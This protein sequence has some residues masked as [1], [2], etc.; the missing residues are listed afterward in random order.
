M[1]KSI[2]KWILL[3]V[4]GACVC[5][6][7]IAA[8]VTG[9]QYFHMGRTENTS[10]VYFYSPGH[11]SHYAAGDF[12]P[13]HI[14][15]RD[16]QKVTRVEFWVNG[17][18]VE[19]KTSPLQGGSSPMPLVLDWQPPAGG[20]YTLVA[21]AVNSRGEKTTG[22]IKVLVS[23]EM[24]AAT[25]DGD[26]D[27]IID[28]AD[29]CPG[30]PGLEPDGCPPV[31]PDADGDGVEDALDECP[32][33]VGGI[34]AAGCPDRDGDGVPDD[35]DVCPDETGASDSPAGVGC[36]S[37][38]A[39][40]RDGDGV[41]DAED[42]C[43][44][45]PGAVENAGCPEDTIVPSGVDD[46]PGAFPAEDRDGDGIAD[47][48][49]LCPGEAGPADEH[50]CPVDAPDRDGDGIP[51][52]AD[53]CPDEP[54]D[55]ANMGCPAPEEA[56]EDSSGGFLELIP[57][58]A[59]D[60]SAA[61]FVEFQALSFSVAQPYDEVYCY[62]SVTQNPPDLYGPFHFNG[63]R[64]WDITEYMGSMQVAVHEGENLPVFV[65]CFAYS[66][67]SGSSEYHYI[68]QYAMQHPASDWDGHIITARVDP[69]DNPVGSAQ[70]DTEGFQATYRICDGACDPNL[71]ASPVLGIREDAIMGRVLFW[72]WDG[73]PANVD[74][75]NIY[76]NGT[77]W[78]NI[79]S[80]YQGINVDSLEPAC[81]QT[82]SF[83][84]TAAAGEV[85]SPMSNEVNWAGPPC[86]QRV[87]ITFDKIEIYNVRDGLRHGEVGP[88]F[89]RFYATGSLPYELSFDGDDFP[90][91]VVLNSEG[92]TSVNAL[93]R[94]IRRLQENEGVCSGYTCHNYS[95]PEVSYIEMDLTAGT[96]LTVGVRITDEDVGGYDTL[97]Q[98]EYTFPYDEIVPGHYSLG[99]GTVMVTYWI[100]TIETEDAGGEGGTG[101]QPDLQ[102]TRVEK[103]PNSGQVRSWVVNNGAPIT[104]QTLYILYM[105]RDGGTILLEQLYEGVSL[106]TDE[107]VWLQTSRTDIPISN[108]SVFVDSRFQVDEANEDNNQLLT[109][110]TYAVRLERIWN[111]SF[112]ENFL[113]QHVEFEYFYSVGY[114]PDEDHVHW[115]A[116]RLR[117]PASDYDR[118]DRD[119]PL[120]E[121]NVYPATAETR[122]NVFITPNAGDNIYVILTGDEHDP[123]QSDYLGMIFVVYPPDQYQAGRIEERYVTEGASRATCADM[124][125]LGPENEFYAWFV[126]EPLP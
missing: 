57:G 112:C 33:A 46:D 125:P 10:L 99:N 55:P 25:P 36:P 95:A 123:N 106:A 30:Q 78:R 62:A 118:I 86:S 80:T 93:F 89:G 96:D 56:G 29:A 22:E 115:V 14:V 77:Y 73:D 88:V 121:R 100:N 94:T 84:I 110:V 116:N 68:G 75:F 98:D 92:S 42:A 124:E 65:S 50:G 26:G 12:V 6:G 37:V 34:A 11:N 69:V 103:E 45:E 16:E 7:L 13:I 43:P 8:G 20:T 41:L 52:S 19:S 83:R 17:R 74:Q 21:Q 87:R 38:T 49:D 79:R 113:Q 119:V 47:G 18:L 81:G 59:F 76:A 51:D 24:S 109:P 53:A 71:L 35:V 108:I 3:V 97:V 114:G 61:H 91:G 72:S 4:I 70:A 102:I 15:A 28:P 67:A 39:D 101:P 107:G 126:I 40:D 54:G 32:D 66:G 9:W 23:D 58:F 60:L 90:Y 31:L 111:T 122:F 2:W 105:T 63:D 64:S 120:E 27:G 1:R 5:C 117:Y 48:V 85:E 104:D 44:D 82:V